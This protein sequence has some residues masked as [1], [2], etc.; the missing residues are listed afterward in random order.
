MSAKKTQWSQGNGMI[1][2]CLCVFCVNIVTSVVNF[3]KINWQ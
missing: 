1:H 2:F 3:I